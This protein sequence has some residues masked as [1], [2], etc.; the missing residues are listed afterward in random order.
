MS[1]HE[2]FIGIYENAYSQDF[3]DRA[4]KY[5]NSMIEAGFGRTRQQSEQ[6]KAHLK[7]DLTVF[8]CQEEEISLSPSRTLFGEFLDLFWANGYNKYIENFSIIDNFDKHNVFAFRVQKTLIGGGYHTWHCEQMTK[9]T[10]N[11]VLAWMLYLNDVEE[12][13]ETEFLYIPK[14]IKPKAGT[15]VIW[16]SGFTHTHRGNPPISN[17]KYAITGWVEF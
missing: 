12:G 15:L 4:I 17:T 8:P 7:D 6:F 5:H 13:G 10:S 11:R 16:P 3:C 1:L 9:S 2:N 14:R